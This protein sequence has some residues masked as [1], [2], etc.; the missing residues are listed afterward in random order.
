MEQLKI[1]APDFPIVG[2]AASVS[3]CVTTIEVTSSDSHKSDPSKN[4]DH[5]PHQL[6]DTTKSEST[7]N[8]SKQQSLPNRPENLPFFPIEE[9]N[10]KMEQWLLN[11]FSASTFNSCPHQPLPMMTGPP[12]SIH[13]D[14]ATKPM[15][16]HAPTLIHIHWNEEVKQQLDADVAL[17]VIK[18]VEPKTPTTWCH[19]AIWVRK[20]DGNPRRVVNF[21]SLNRHCFCD[22]HHTVSP[23]QQAHEIS[24][25]TYCSVTDAWNGYHLVPVREEDRH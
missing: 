24:R 4:A 3:N 2:A 10:N 11:R 25:N 5:S 1:I 15:A 17:G 20:L 22:T 7:C 8:C 16:V 9:N 19:C 6:D 21:Q 14:L 12:I 13:I 18:K 23:F